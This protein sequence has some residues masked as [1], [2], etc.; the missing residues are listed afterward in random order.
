MDNLELDP[1][2]LET[3]ATVIEGYCNRQ[4]SIM[5]DYLSSITSLSSEWQDDETL[6]PLIE[7]IRRMKTSVINVMDEIMAIYPNY[8]RNKAAQIGSRPKL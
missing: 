2:V 3:T 8:F 5:D 1:A 7:E 6:G 4:K